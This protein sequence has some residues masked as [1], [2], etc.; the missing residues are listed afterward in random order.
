MN[1]PNPNILHIDLGNQSLQS[2]LIAN[3]YIIYSELVRFSEKLLKEDLDAIEAVLVSN[4]SDN[5]VFVLEKKNIHITLEKAM[6]Y[7]LEV[8]EYEK[9]SKI[10]D[11]QNLL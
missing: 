10:R 2:W 1:K 5:V 6:A 9:C 4:L 8:E 11:L 3:R 7:F